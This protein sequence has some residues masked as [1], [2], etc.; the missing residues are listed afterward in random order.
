MTAPRES[1][2]ERLPAIRDN[3][4]ILAVVGPPEFDAAP[5]DDGW[6][7]SDFF[8]AN[9]L[10]RGLGKSQRWMTCVD[11]QT[12]IDGY[13]EYVFGSPYEERRVVLDQNQRPQNVTVHPP[14]DLRDEFLARIQDTV[15]LAA[16]TNDHVLVLFFGHGRELSYGLEIGADSEGEPLLLTPEE[17][18][19]VVASAPDLDITLYL[20]S[21]YSGGWVES[22]WLRNN[23]G[24][25][26]ITTMA[27]AKKA[28]MSESLMA[29]ISGRIG[30][31]IFTAAVIQTL[32]REEG[33][34]RPGNKEYSHKS[35]LDLTDDIRNTLF[36]EID[37]RFPKP[38]VF[39]AQN[40]NWNDPFYSRTGIPPILYQHRFNELRSIPPSDLNPMQD[41]SRR[42]SRVS[43]SEVAAWRARNPDSSDDSFTSRGAFAS[44]SARRGIPMRI[45]VARAL[46]IQYMTSNPLRDTVGCNV[47]AHGRFRSLIE[48]TLSEDHLD[49]AVECLFS[50]LESLATSEVYAKMMGLSIPPI[51][52][53]NVDKYLYNA[54][55]A[56][57]IEAYYD[58][59]LYEVRIRADILFPVPKS[60][61]PADQKTRMYLACAFTIARMKESAVIDALDKLVAAVSK[62]IEVQTK[63]YR[64][65]GRFGR[66]ISTVKRTARSL[67]PSKRLRKSL[68]ESS[69]PQK[70]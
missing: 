9:H 50:R 35:Y 34:D 25:S 55:N 70:S 11:P 17:V 28:T 60:S 52:A 29:S 69:D 64:A 57:D 30:G 68:G 49:D 39:G 22:P 12:L 8:L 54:A 67:S 15:A 38:P 43:D 61:T 14:H 24:K 32:L 56:A 45:S 40:E 4:H 19:P 3:T 20:T 13:G 1:S 6:F 21:C 31:S 36:D 66:W 18:R 16:K 23:D 48:G 7:F 58:P 5:A 65:T 37:V 42:L 44:R 46:A 33:L 47:S 41:R 51:A 59:A 2:L 63:A 26:L 62:D 10:F 27:A 53:F